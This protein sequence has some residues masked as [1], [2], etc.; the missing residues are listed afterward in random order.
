VPAAFLLRVGI[1]IDDDRP[2]FLVCDL[3]YPPPH[4]SSVVALRF[5]SSDDLVIGIDVDG[6]RHAKGGYR[7][8][9]PLL[10]RLR[11]HQRYPAPPAAAGE[12]GQLVNG[13]EIP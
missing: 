13:S 8:R 12:E 9:P 4:H 1:E 5:S 7:L 2:A 10:N 11:P 3:E 6:P